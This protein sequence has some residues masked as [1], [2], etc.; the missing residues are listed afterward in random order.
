MNANDDLAEAYALGFLEE[1]EAA[2]LQARLDAAR[3]DDDRALAAAVGL[4]R[5][6]LLP[7]DLTAAELPLGVDAWTRMEALLPAP[8]PGYEPTP[9]VA[10]SGRWRMTAIASM[11]AALLLAVGLAWQIFMNQPPSVIAVL[12][13]ESGGPVATVEVTSDNRVMVTPLGDVNVGPTEVF[14]LWTK[15]DPDGPPI[16]LGVLEEA[17]RK[18]LVESS[19]P[20]PVP[21]QFF[22]ITREPL[23]GSPTGLPTGPIIGK[24]NAQDID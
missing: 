5:D 24:G 1:E 17:A 10:S 21:G 4:Y 3:T 13:D 23:G 16:S 6:R 11:A 15:P 7:L 19:L 9:L 12:L 14:Q 2:A 22:E 8:P 20:A 18:A